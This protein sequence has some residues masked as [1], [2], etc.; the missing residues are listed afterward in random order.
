MN[1]DD[2]PPLDSVAETDLTELELSD[3]DILDA[4]R[5]IPGYLDITT[6]DF[7]TIYHLAHRHA[8]ER[9]FNQVRAGQLMRTGVEP[10]QLDTRLDQAA[11]SLVTQGCKGLPVADADG[12]II[13]MLTETD[14]LRRLGADSFMGLLLRLI[15]DAGSFTHRCHATPV[16]EAMTCP[17]VTVTAD[18]GVGDILRAFRAHPGRSMAVVDGRGAFRGLLLRKD[19]L[20]ACGLEDLQ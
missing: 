13:G 1:R 4:M 18:A 9:L 6:Q 2:K 16:S 20:H 15:A 10:L 17:A 14:F 3:D 5:E 8:V 12:K 7:R 11:H 19:F